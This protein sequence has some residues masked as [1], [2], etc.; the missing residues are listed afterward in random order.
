MDVPIACAQGIPPVVESVHVFSHPFLR[1]FD[2]KGKSYALHTLGMSYVDLTCF[3]KYF[4]LPD[5]RS[6][7]YAAKVFRPLFEFIDGGPD[8]YLN[9]LVEASRFWKAFEVA[10]LPHLVAVVHTVVLQDRKSELSNAQVVELLDTSMV[11]FALSLGS[12]S[13]TLQN[14]PP[15]LFAQGQIQRILSP[16]ARDILSQAS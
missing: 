2:F 12:P 8:N 9:V 5:K 13:V 16:S 14:P 3:A 1:G 15:V 6:E 11:R 4:S 10:N 7:E